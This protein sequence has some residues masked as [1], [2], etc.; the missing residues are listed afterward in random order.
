[1]YV[2][3]YEGMSVCMYVCMY[4]CV[5]V[6]MYVCIYVVLYVCMYLCMYVC[7]SVSMYV[8]TYICMSVCLSA[9]VHERVLKRPPGSSLSLH[10]APLN[11]SARPQNISCSQDPSQN[12]KRT[13]AE[14]CRA[15]TATRSSCR[16]RPIQSG[17]CEG[18]AETC[19]VH[20]SWSHKEAHGLRQQGNRVFE[21]AEGAS[22]G[23]WI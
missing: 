1:M 20:F 18:A 7:M 12:N 6:S 3:M 2:C 13:Q 23:H 4:V 10:K 5:C 19:P 22:C 14:S 8:C 21:Q 11:P 15:S 17:S 9:F 16:A